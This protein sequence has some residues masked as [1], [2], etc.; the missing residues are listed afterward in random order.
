MPTRAMIVQARPQAGT[1]DDARQLPSRPRAGWD[2][3]G[4][5]P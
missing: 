3:Y 4:L 1:F 5:P 2:P